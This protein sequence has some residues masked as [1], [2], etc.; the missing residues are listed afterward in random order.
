MFQPATPRRRALWRTAAALL[1]AGAVT[2]GVIAAR[3]RT[4]PAPTQF[5]ARKALLGTIVSITVVA[6]DERVARE[7]IA[8]AFARISELECA[9]AAQHDDSELSRLNRAAGG[10][11]L[12]VSEDL[13]G[14]IAAGITWHRRTRGAFDIA[15]GPLLARWTQCGKSGRL[16]T[17]AETAQ[18]LALIGADRVV[19]DDRARSVRLPQKGMRLHLGGLGKGY[20]ADAVA[21]LLRERGVTSALVAA[22]GDIRALGRR[23]DGTAWRIGVQDPRR[24]DDATALVTVLELADQAVSTSGNYTR[25][26]EID[27]RKYSHII[28]PRTGRTAD[29]VPSVTVVGPDTL[30]TDVLGTALSVMGTEEGLAF[31]ESLEGIEALFMN[32]EE[33]R[34]PVL[35]RSRGFAAY[36][37]SRLPAGG[38]K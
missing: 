14:A 5:S 23:A 32:F 7:H 35:T 29:N 2:A 17:E 18:A 26:V 33:E 30:T 19:L 31:V 25:Y 15:A 22:S 9:L 28:D 34:R 16:P 21:R 1:A 24:P 37:V 10:P 13:Y 36:E 8:A 38:R 3:Q 4:P 6:A 11:A 12:A 27:G 20:C